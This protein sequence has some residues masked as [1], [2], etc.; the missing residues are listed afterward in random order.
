MDLLALAFR[1]GHLDLSMFGD[2]LDDGELFITL[3]AL[4]FVCGHFNPPFLHDIG[5]VFAPLPRSGTVALLRCSRCSRRCVY[6]NESSRLVKRG[7][8]IPGPPF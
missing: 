2:A 4:I 8:E 3:P 5:L 7:L 6:L 1:A